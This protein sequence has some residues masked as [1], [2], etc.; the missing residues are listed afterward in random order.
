[1]LPPIIDFD[2]IF[3]PD[4]AARVPMVAAALAYE[5]F[6]IGG[7]RPK[8]DMTALPLLGL[9][10]WNNP[11]VAENGGLYVRN[12]AFVDAFTNFGDENEQT[13]QFV[14]DFIERNDRSP[15]LFEALAYEVGKILGAAIDSDPTNRT[16]M[17][18]ALSVSQLTNSI[19]GGGSFT[20]NGEVSRT[21]RVLTITDEGLVPWIDPDAE[22]PTTGEVSPE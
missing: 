17:R 16:E 14:T 10:G 15:V 20:E 4:N 6:A 21:M 9:N 7:F 1:M 12:S 18:E 2:A 13:L 22:E 8:R 3:V 19:A 5:E 11:R